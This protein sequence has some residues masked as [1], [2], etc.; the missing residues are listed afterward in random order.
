MTPPI[1]M[2][3]VPVEPTEAMLEAA[4]KI[5][6]IMAGS[7]MSLPDMTLYLW[8][9]MLTAA[10][11]REEGGAV[12]DVVK[13]ATDLCHA[14]EQLIYGLPKYLDAENLTDEE[15]M[16]REAWI[17]LDVTAHR[18]AA[19]ATREEAPAKAGERAVGTIAHVSNGRS[20]LPEL[21]ASALRAQPQAREEAPPVC[22]EIPLSNHMKVTLEYDPDGSRTAMLWN[23]ANEPI[24]DGEAPALTTPPAP[25]AD[26]LRVALDDSRAWHT[27]RH[28][29]LSKQPP[30]P[31]RDWRKAEH[32]EEIARIEAALQ[33]E[34]QA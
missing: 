29:A 30:S 33:Q 21:I 24:A 9:A 34:G 14:Y 26:K 8:S 32:A 16:I 10:P 13:I 5:G 20:E 6:M 23:E 12:D 2:V 25:G 18:L 28:K 31:D 4:E 19:L 22:L 3:S 7:D 1:R 11:V 15:N 27:E 17:T